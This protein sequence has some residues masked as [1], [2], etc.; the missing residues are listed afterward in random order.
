MIVFIIFIFLLTFA[1]VAVNGLEHAKYAK[2]ETQLIPEELAVERHKEVQWIQKPLEEQPF[3]I[4]MPGKTV[5]G[6][7]RVEEAA[8][9]TY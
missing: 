3:A 5:C 1:I 8:L 2:Q 6:R 4:Y 9:K 7:K